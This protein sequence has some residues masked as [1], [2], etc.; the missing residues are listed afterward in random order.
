MGVGGVGERVVLHMTV[1][2]QHDGAKILKSDL[3]SI[4]QK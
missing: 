1:N 2:K 4:L 3:L